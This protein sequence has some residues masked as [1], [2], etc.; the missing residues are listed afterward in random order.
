MKLK[1]LR[2]FWNCLSFT[3]Y[4]S[5]LFSLWHTFFRTT[6]FGFMI[7]I[8]FSICFNTPTKLR[9]RKKLVATGSDLVVEAI[10]T[11]SIFHAQENVRLSKK[12]FLLFSIRSDIWIGSVCINKVNYWEFETNAWRVLYVRLTVFY[13]TKLS[14]K[15][16][17]VR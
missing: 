11:I 10:F 12:K 3:I 9:E 2:I 13:W 8:I 1:T 17:I 16:S 7:I 15:F 4:F 14:R 5:L 6:L